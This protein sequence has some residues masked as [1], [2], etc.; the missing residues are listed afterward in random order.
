LG[1]PSGDASSPTD[2]VDVKL[3]PFT[4]FWEKQ[5]HHDVHVKITAVYIILEKTAP[6]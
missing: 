2:D 4:L 1:C 5:L 6:P 3:P